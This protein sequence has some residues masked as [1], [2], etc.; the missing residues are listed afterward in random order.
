MCAD[1][2]QG[3]ISSWFLRPHEKQSYGQVVMDNNGTGKAYCAAYHEDLDTNVKYSVYVED[4][5]VYVG[6]EACH[7]GMCSS[8][9]N[10]KEVNCTCDEDQDEQEFEEDDDSI[11][12]S[13]QVI[14]NHLGMKTWGA[15]VTV[16]NPAPGQKFVCIARRELRN[17]DSGSSQAQDWSDPMVLGTFEFVNPSSPP[18]PQLPTDTNQLLTSIIPV[19]SLFILT[20]AAVAVI[21]GTYFEYKRRKRKRGI[22]MNYIDI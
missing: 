4:V 14:P 17:Q 3:G 1:M 13:H 2:R 12:C 7:L 19:G 20:L 5:N 22:Y 16:K 9:S 21:V 18:Q 11:S 6:L 8:R 15:V 10:C